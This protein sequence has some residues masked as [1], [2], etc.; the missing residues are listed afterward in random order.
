MKNRNLF[1]WQ[2][3]RSDLVSFSYFWTITKQFLMK[4]YGFFTICVIILLIYLKYFETWKKLCKFYAIFYEKFILY[5]LKYTCF[6]V[7]C[8]NGS[9]SFM[10]FSLIVGLYRGMAYWGMIGDAWRSLRYAWKIVRNVLRNSQ[11]I[12]RETWWKL[13][14]IIRIHFKI[15][16]SR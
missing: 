8:V 3:K 13:Q 5:W 11:R 1:S 6:G 12:F 14:E 7:I 15:N 9:H 10:R 4:N 16:D 2:M